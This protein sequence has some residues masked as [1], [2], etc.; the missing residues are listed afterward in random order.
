MS[1]D[2]KRDCGIEF[3]S[4]FLKIIGGVLSDSWENK[5]RNIMLK[6]LF[7]VKIFCLLLVSGALNVFAFDKQLEKTLISM[8]YKV[9]GK[10]ASAGADWELRDFKMRSKQIYNIKSTK[11]VPGEKNLYY[12][13][14][15]RIE[16]YATVEDAQ[17]RLEHIQSTPP[18][19]D[20]K[21]IAPEFDLRE[22]FQRGTQVYVVSTDVYTFVVDKS[23]SKLREKLKMAITKNDKCLE[24]NAKCK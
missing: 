20:S 23:L 22:G 14:T 6:K 4:L 18:G 19:A 9:T 15:I 16:Q 11:K 1:K 12:R 17:I 2:E 10:I 24:P 8:G 7:T 13:F 5:E 3:W 21:M